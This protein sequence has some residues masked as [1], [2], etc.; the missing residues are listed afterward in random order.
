MATI[1]LNKDFVAAVAAGKKIFRREDF[2]AIGISKEDKK[3]A[4]IVDCPRWDGWQQGTGDGVK[5][6]VNGTC[7]TCYGT[8]NMTSDEK[9]WYYDHKGQGTGTPRSSAA[10]EKQTVNKE[11]LLEFLQTREEWNTPE[12]LIL[13]KMNHCKDMLIEYVQTEPKWATKTLLMLVQM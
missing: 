6:N 10:A 12:L 8:S 13:L 4:G 5:L 2:E 9:R 1:E 11:M 7:V 3:S